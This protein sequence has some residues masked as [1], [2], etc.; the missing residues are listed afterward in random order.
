M[1]ICCSLFVEISWGFPE[2]CLEL[3]IS[4]FGVL[5]LGQNLA[6]VVDRLNTL[7]EVSLNQPF[8]VL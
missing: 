5:I 3:F 1:W 4:A 8:G 6:L 2:E 7:F